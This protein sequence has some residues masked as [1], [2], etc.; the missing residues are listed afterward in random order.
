MSRRY[1]VDAFTDV[2]F[3]GDPAAVCPLA[4][5]ASDEWMP[6]VAAEMN[7]SETAFVT[8]LDDGHGLRWFTPK[9]EVRL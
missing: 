8:K 7:R 4:M 6:S 9:R 3:R 1:H 5:P 2:P